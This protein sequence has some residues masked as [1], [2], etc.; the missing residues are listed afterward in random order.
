MGEKNPNVQTKHTFWKRRVN[1]Q[2]VSTNEEY[3]TELRNYWLNELPKGQAWQ[4]R[5][6]VGII[7]QIMTLRNKHFQTLNQ[8][9]III[10]HLYL[11]LNPVLLLFAKNFFLLIYLFVFLYSRYTPL[12]NF[13]QN[14]QKELGFPRPKNTH[15]NKNAQQCVFP[16]SFFILRTTIWHPTSSAQ[17]RASCS[18]MNS[19]RLK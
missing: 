9:I 2:K 12:Q 6:L 7:H 8:Q 13:H 19:R 4:L 1:L 16:P 3:P 10:Y 5:T 14:T 17:F 18:D 11:H 15:S